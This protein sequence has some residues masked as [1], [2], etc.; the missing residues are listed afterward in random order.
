MSEL[1]NQI[2][3]QLQLHSQEALIK[4]RAQ[5][6]WYTGADLLEDIALCK[7][8]LQQQSVTAG[9][10]M[11]ISV[12][13]T[14][15]LPVLLLASWQLGINVTLIQPS[16]KL[17]PALAERYT[18]MVYAT[19]PTQSLAA[20][21]NPQEMSLLTLILNTAPNFAYFVHDLAPSL[22]QTPEANLQVT[23][24]TAACSQQELLDRA[25]QLTPPA[26][27]TNLYDLEHGILPLLAN[28]LDPTP[29]ALAWAG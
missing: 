29:F 1:T 15:V 11:L 26:T 4:N 21:L 3:T 2:T 6:I 25:Q 17:T 7:A 5:G 14:A 10:N 22:T 8:S 27:I 9:Q 24:T 18:A 28:L 12:D 19:A 20:Q 16:T 13:N 23:P